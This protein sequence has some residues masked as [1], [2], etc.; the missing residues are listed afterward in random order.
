MALRGDEKI[1]HKTRE[2]IREVAER[3]G[4]IPNVAACNLV[5]GKTNAIGIVTLQSQNS[6]YTE[7]LMELEQQ[8]LKLG[9]KFRIFLTDLNQLE[10][11]KYLL[12]EISG[13]VDGLIFYTLP[14][15]KWGY[16]FQ[17]KIRKAK[18]KYVLNRYT[19]DKFS[20]WVSADHWK[21][22]Y[23][24]GKYLINKGHTRICTFKCV[25]DYYGTPERVHGFEH[26]LREHGMQLMCMNCQDVTI[27]SF[28]D[29]Y[30]I[31]K[32]MLDMKPRP[33]TIFMRS[34]FLAICALRVISE[35]GLKAG[36]DINV[37]GY[38]NTEMGNYTVP[39]LTTVDCNYREQ[40]KQ[41]CRILLAR[42]NGDDSPPKNILI[43]PKLVI[44]ESA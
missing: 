24:T 9:Y 42:I 1:N 38:D 16:S 15:K 30:S 37:V 29:G 25:S 21:G 11:Q 20:D 19:D 41:L 12:N 22:G 2:R 32:K 33:T 43:E 10:Q 34:D 36:K 6:T 31:A 18:I 5:G 35:I 7:Y 3:L 17:E 8:L 13:I 23:L 27:R 26:A 40:A 14:V 28:R 44:R 4:Y 39:S